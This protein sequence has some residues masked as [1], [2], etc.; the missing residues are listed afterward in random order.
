MLRVILCL[1]SAPFLC[2]LQVRTKANTAEEFYDYLDV[3]YQ[4]AKRVAQ[5]IEATWAFFVAVN[6]VSGQVPEE[7]G[8]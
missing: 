2:R 5:L 4:G 6:K 3:S 8:N 7:S 1:P